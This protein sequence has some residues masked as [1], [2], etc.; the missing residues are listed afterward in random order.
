[1]HVP[2]VRFF[3][4]IGASCFALLLA[5][6]TLAWNS[7]GHMIIALIAYDQLD[8]A[9]RT[10]AV[11]LI[12]SHPRFHDH[13]QRAMPNEVSRL[14]KQEQDEW[15]CAYAA[16]WPDQVREAKFGVDR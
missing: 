12:R 3:A 16:T 2:P 6:T 13:F 14:N 11:E 4:W 7:P 8:D 10:K 5:S 9:T 15:L 1:M